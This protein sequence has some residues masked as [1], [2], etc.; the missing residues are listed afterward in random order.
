[1]D[2]ISTVEDLERHYGSVSAPALVKVARTIT[3]HYAAYIE[4][5]PFCAFA[6]VGPEG[7]DCSPRGDDGPVVQIVSETRLA[8]PDR[9]GNNRIDTL[10][11]I[12]RDPRV[13]LMFLIPGSPTVIRVNG[14]ALVTA[15]PA[16]LDAYA[17]HGKP[18]RTVTFVDV[19]EVYFQCARAVNRAGLWSGRHAD[20]AALPSVGAMLEACSSEIDGAAYDAEWPGRA[21]TTMW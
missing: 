17:I 6:S 14:R 21:A 3:P 20:L 8:L 4:A 16:V 2:V 5:S 19:D 10:R 7:L 15:D 1:M 9:R 11:N 12:V 18:P 13:S